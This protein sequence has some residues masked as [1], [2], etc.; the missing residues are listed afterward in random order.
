MNNQ[1]ELNKLQE[2][3]R[4]KIN[5]LYTPLSQDKLKE[6]HSLQPKQED[7]IT[8]QQIR[9]EI[10]DITFHTLNNNAMEPKA[11]I[12]M[13]ELRSGTVFIGKALVANPQNYVYELGQHYSYQDAIKQ[14]FPIMADRQG[15]SRYYHKKRQKLLKDAL[16]SAEECGDDFK[17]GWEVPTFQI[18]KMTE[19]DV[20][21]ID[22][23]KQETSLSNAGIGDAVFGTDVSPKD[24]DDV[25]NT[26]VYVNIFFRT[27]GT[28]SKVEQDGKDITDNVRISITK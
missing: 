10:I 19:S 1:D 6:L 8:E 26:E 28:I 12:C 15:Q 25:S 4:N 22:P 9:D 24:P 23:I 5:E 16:K 7:R 21:N 13:I 2:E 17:I 11:V 14:I 27:D 18:G 3:H 20:F